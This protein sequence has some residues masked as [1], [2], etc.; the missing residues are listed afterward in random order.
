MKLLQLFYY[1]CICFIRGVH[2]FFTAI[3][4]MSVE[5]TG[6]K[7][8]IALVQKQECRHLKNLVSL[9]IPSPICAISRV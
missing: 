7:S 2:Y 4:K 8:R 9:S 3:W 5:M 6:S 1:A